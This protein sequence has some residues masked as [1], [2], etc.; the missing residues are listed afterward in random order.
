MCR[1]V[2]VC[3][4]TIKVDHIALLIDHHEG[5]DSCLPLRDS[6]RPHLRPSTHGVLL[7]EAEDGRVVILDREPVPVVLCEHLIQ[8]LLR[9]I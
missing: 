3:T 2:C 9:F 8:L 1:L 7:L 4:R 6:T 5:G